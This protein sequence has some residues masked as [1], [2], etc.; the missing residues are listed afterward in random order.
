[1]L[2]I[3]LQISQTSPTP[4][5]KAKSHTCTMNSSHGRF[6]GS[7]GVAGNLQSGCKSKA[8]IKT[9]GCMNVLRKWSEIRV[10]HSVLQQCLRFQSNNGLASSAPWLWAWKWWICTT[11]NGLLI[12]YRACWTVVCARLCR[13]YLKTGIHYLS[14]LYLQ[15]NYILDYQYFSSGFYTKPVSLNQLW[16]KVLNTKCF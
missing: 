2:M 16:F 10:A 13:L 1:M 8:D 11:E 3:N 14:A 6:F 5:H 15:Y 7:S 12:I 4:G 9:A